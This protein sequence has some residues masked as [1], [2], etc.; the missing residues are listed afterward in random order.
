ME[1]LLFNEGFTQTK[2]QRITDVALENQHFDIIGI[3]AHD[4]KVPFLFMNPSL[5]VMTPRR[6][7]WDS[8]FKRHPF[9]ILRFLGCFRRNLSNANFLES[10]CA[11]FVCFENTQKAPET[12]RA[13]LKSES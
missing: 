6:D 13:F 7:A 12:E 8:L 4:I 3:I 1:F 11:T 5:S 2:N 9:L 10:S